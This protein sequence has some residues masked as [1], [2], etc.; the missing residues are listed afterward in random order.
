MY[1]Y[2]REEGRKEGRTYRIIIQGG[3]KK[4][5]ATPFAYAS[6]LRIHSFVLYY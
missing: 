4:G 1:A 3:E 6:K 5:E 2:L